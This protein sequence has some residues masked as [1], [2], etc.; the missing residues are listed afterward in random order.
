MYQ[1]AIVVGGKCACHMV[2]TEASVKF[3]DTCL[4]TIRGSRLMTYLTWGSETFHYC[5]FSP[6]PQYFHVIPYSLKMSYRELYGIKFM[7]IP[8]ILSEDDAFMI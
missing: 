1:A 6:D 7:V 8:L 4:G 5:L 3:H 2:R